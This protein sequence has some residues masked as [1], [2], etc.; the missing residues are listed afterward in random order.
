MLIGCALLPFRAP[1][2]AISSSYEDGY[3]AGLRA[4]GAGI[5]LIEPEEYDF[6]LNLNK[7]TIHEAGKKCG[8][9]VQYNTAYFIGTAEELREALIRLGWMDGWMEKVNTMIAETASRM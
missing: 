3:A 7:R 2:A 1:S 8:P 9:D 5:L 6:V 4:A